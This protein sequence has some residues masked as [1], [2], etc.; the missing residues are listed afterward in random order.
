MHSPATAKIMADLILHGTTDLID[1]GML[2]CA[3]FRGGR[4]IEE[5]SVYGPIATETSFFTR[6]RLEVSKSP[7]SQ[8]TACAV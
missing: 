1:A 5:T 6:L 8:K 2:D 7:D 3:R 4:L